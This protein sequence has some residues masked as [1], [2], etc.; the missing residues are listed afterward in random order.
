MER[1]WLKR[2]A[3]FAMR[4]VAFRTSLRCSADRPQSSKFLPER[5]ASRTYR[6]L[7]SRGVMSKSCSG[8]VFRRARCATSVKTAVAA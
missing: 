4:L 5:S 7:I 8:T 1:T 3:G 6:L 2:P